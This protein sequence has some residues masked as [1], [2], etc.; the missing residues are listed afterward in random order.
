MARFRLLLAIP[1]A[2]VLLFAPLG[3]IYIVPQIEQVPV[4][5][6]IGNLEKIAKAEPQNAEVR[7][8]GVTFID[9]T[10]RPTYDVLLHRLSGG[11]RSKAKGGM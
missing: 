10:T 8:N 9:G 6:V 4:S 5:R 1:V 3:A 11:R 2:L 7:V